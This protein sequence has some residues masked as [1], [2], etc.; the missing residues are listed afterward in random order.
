V[1]AESSGRVAAAVVTGV[2]AIGG[3]LS[4]AASFRDRPGPADLNDPSTQR[5]ARRLFVSAAAVLNVVGVALLVAGIGDRDDERSGGYIGM[6]I[7]LIG[8]LGFPA[9]CMAWNVNRQITATKP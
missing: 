8:L 2:L 3:I 7:I 9:A 6:G 5:G 1:F 4:F